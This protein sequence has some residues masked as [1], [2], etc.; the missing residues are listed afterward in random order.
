LTVFQGLLRC[1]G[2]RPLIVARRAGASAGL[3]TWETCS[4]GGEPAS[5]PDALHTSFPKTGTVSSFEGRVAVEVNL[6][7]PVWS[8]EK[9]RFKCTGLQEIDPEQSL[10]GAT[11]ISFH[12]RPRSTLPRFH[13]LA[14]TS[15][16]SLR[17][18]PTAPAAIASSSMQEP[19]DVSHPTP[20]FIKPGDRRR[21]PGC[22]K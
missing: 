18:V 6:D 9:I 17:S 22:L 11:P 12:K 3:E 1:R 16:A 8:A 20:S 5:I 13:R 15:I 7:R 21:D 19:G 10:S 4:R 2:R 14:A